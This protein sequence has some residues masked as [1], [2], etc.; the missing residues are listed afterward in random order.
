[1]KLA[2]ITCWLISFTEFCLV[3]SGG[4][5]AKENRICDGGVYQNPFILGHY[6]MTAFLMPIILVGMFLLYLY[7]LKIAFLQVVQ[8]RGNVRVSQLVKLRQEEARSKFRGVVT[9]AIVVGAFCF[10]WMPSSA[11]YIYI[12][13]KRGDVSQHTYNILHFL[14]EYPAFLN[15]M[16]N[17]IIYA[18]RN[19]EFRLAYSKTWKKLVQCSKLIIVNQD[20]HSVETL[21]YEVQMQEQNGRIV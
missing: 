19:R 8:R 10:C 1:M 2:L 11:R 9:M 13:A 5:N 20:T 12:L 6:L 4:I 15:A 18:F 14:T 16:L 3:L 21:N 7:M 17:P